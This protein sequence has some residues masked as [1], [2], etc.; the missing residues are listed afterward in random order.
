MSELADAFEDLY[1]KWLEHEK[2]MLILE[3]KVDSI[4]RSVDTLLKVLSGK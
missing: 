1:N 2:R 4:N 3:Q